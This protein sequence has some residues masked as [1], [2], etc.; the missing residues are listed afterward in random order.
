MVNKIVALCALIALAGCGVSQPGPAV[1]TACEW[2]GP[3]LV[4][5]ADILTAPTA[6]EI[7]AHNRKWK[8]NCT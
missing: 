8:R 1:D 7:L 5:K 2:V 4:G 6:A 3:I